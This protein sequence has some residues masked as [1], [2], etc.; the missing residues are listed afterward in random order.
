M[1]IENLLFIGLFL[2]IL[3]VRAIRP[4]R[5]RPPPPVVEG[6]E[7]V[8]GDDGFAVDAEAPPARRHIAR[9]RGP[10][11]GPLAPA[12]PASRDTARARRLG[13][14]AG[15]RRGIVLMTILGPCRALQPPADS[16]DG[17]GSR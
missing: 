10:A 12:G 3:L 11:R 16:M 14:P 1:T 17:S 9:G 15:V 2:L 5:R 6:V 4:R 13:G 7:V 8:E